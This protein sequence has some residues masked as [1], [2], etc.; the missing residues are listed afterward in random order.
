MWP[1]LQP[2]IRNLVFLPREH[3]TVWGFCC[4]GPFRALRES[5]WYDRS[6]GHPH[7]QH[8]EMKLDPMVS[9]PATLS[10]HSTPPS[11]RRGRSGAWLALGLG[12]IL[13]AVPAQAAPPVSFELITESGYSPTESQKWLQF[14]AKVD[15]TSIRI[16]G[17]EA[18]EREQIT[19]RG[20]EERPLYHVL[21]VLT[22]RNRMRVP[23]AEF[24]LSDR[25]RL[26]AWLRKLE[27]EGIVDE[28]AA[29]AAFGLTPDQ[30]V[31]FHEKIAGPIAVDTKGRRCGDVARDIVKGLALEYTV[32]TAATRA[33]A[34]GEICGDELRGLSAGTALAAAIRPLGLVLRPQKSAKS[35]VLHICEVRETEEAWPVGWPSEE[36]PGQLAP[37]LFES[38][39]VKID[40]IALAKALAAIQGRVAVPFL[41]DHNGIAE[42]D[43]PRGNEGQV[44]GGPGHVPQGARSNSVPGPAV[45]RPPRRRGG[46][47]VSLDLS[48]ITAAGMGAASRCAASGGLGSGCSHR[49]VR[50]TIER[51]L[52]TPALALRQTCPARRI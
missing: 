2:V 24:S 47:A 15:I 45:E 48:Q 50:R 43:R 52:T 26:A 41:F 17:A 36:T 27:S 10:T 44:S 25:E 11:P 42:P 14:L 6:R 35:V 33:F 8:A 18:G 12:C 7:A 40:N 51:H 23:G 20:T 22:H 21:G 9:R 5:A 16:R 30:L 4:D 49:P 19:N 1:G 13:L 34:G 39:L 38:L 3:D 31:G 37:K 46:D 28:G 32:S 29:T